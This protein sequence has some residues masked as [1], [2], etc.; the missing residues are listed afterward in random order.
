MKRF[1]ARNYGAS[2]QIPVGGQSV[3]I[4]NDGIIETDDRSEAKALGAFKQITVTDR[5]SELAPSPSLNTDQKEKPEENR[6]DS[7]NEPEDEAYEDMNLDELQAIAKDR[8]IPTV[9]LD[10]AQLIAVLIAYDETPNEP[11]N[12]QSPKPPEPP[13]ETSDKLAD[14]PIDDKTAEPSENSAE[15]VDEDSSWKTEDKVSVMFNEDIYKGTIK[16]VNKKKKTARV[17]FEDGATET[18]EFKELIRV[19]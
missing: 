8:E 16:S 4:A 5:G 15:T 14:E 13:D 10:E 12:G 19:V 9:G 1:I 6:D 17:A 3:C 11:K 2:R 18:V 7:V